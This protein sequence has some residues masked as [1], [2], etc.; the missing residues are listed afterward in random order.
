MTAQKEFVEL[1]ME[2]KLKMMKNKKS[3]LE[4]QIDSLD[5]RIKR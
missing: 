2:S 4:S 5:K 1:L 3:G